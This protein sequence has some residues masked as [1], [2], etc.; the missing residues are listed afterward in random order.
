MKKKAS[1]QAIIPAS[2]PINAVEHVNAENVGFVLN[3]RSTVQGG[4]SEKRTSEKVTPADSRP[5]EQQ[6]S[7]K[8]AQCSNPVCFAR[9]REIREEEEEVRRCSSDGVCAVL[10]VHYTV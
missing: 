4:Y 3:L 10:S 2:V 6:A 1:Y 7:K 9:E 8:N 5:T